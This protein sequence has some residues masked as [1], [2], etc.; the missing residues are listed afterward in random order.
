MHRFAILCLIIAQLTLAHE[1]LAAGNPVVPDGQLGDFRHGTYP[2][3]GVGDG[4]WTHVG[5]DLVA[6]CGSRVYAFADGKVL[7]LI[8]IPQDSNFD[9]LGYMVLIEHPADLLGKTFYTLYLHIQEP[10]LGTKDDRVK[11]GMTVIGR[12]GTTGAAFGCHT[13]FEVRYF[14]DRFWPEWGDIYGPG[15]QR[16]SELLA[17][18]WE[19]PETLFAR[20]P[21]GLSSSVASSMDS[22]EPTKAL[23]NGR[24]PTASSP[25]KGQVEG[26]KCLSTKFLIRK[27]RL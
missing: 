10:P 8:D 25:L 18:N 13:H 3:I 21:G 19:D 12:V 6:P 16:G 2:S 27:N 1:A 14:P 5:V 20:Y 7:D 9:S 24:S 23:A 15:D 26:G 22:S 4:D 11:G 17:R